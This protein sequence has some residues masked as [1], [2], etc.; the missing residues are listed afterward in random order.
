[1]DFTNL[2]DYNRTETYRPDL[3]P[4]LFNFVIPIFFSLVCVI[5]LIGN[6]IVIYIILRYP[7]MTSLPN[8]YILNLAS[9]DFLFLLGLPF[10]TYFNTTKRWIFGN[11]M[12]K[13][14]MGIDG[15]NM[16]TGIFTLTAMAIDR[17]LAIVHIVWS[18]NYRTVRKTK[19]VCAATWI[20]AFT[21]TVPL[22]MYSAT[23]TFDGVTVCNVIC[24]VLVGQL[25]I[26]YTFLFGFVLPLICII[27]CYCRILRYLTNGRSRQRRRQFHVGR[28]GAMVLFSVILFVICWL[29]FWIIRLLLLS[30]D[31]SLTFALQVSYYVS[32]F[33]SSINSCLN[34]LVYAYFKQDFQDVIKHCIC[35]CKSHDETIPR[36]RCS[37]Y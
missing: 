24:P 32:V 11:V 13:V 23:Q 33:L 17:Y 8:L 12:C 22:W 2:S 31:H 37:S 3:P 15:S 18:K 35:D 9:A 16:F 5:G 7:G 1:M 14:V 21:V 34:P 30:D 29:P 4:W 6:G 26:I 25:F 36:F 19:V 20:G 10:M 28:V 27:T